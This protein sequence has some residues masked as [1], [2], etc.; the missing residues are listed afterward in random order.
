[1]KTFAGWTLLAV[2]LAAVLWSLPG[3]SVLTPPGSVPVSQS[4][5]PQA[6]AAQTAINEA[7]ILLIAASNVIA[8]NVVDG[9]STKEEGR[10]LLARVKALAADVDRAQKLLVAGEVVTAQTQAELTRKL[11]VA[12]HREVAEKARSK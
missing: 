4:L 1:M 2:V 11:L 9:V 6:Q 12:L 5:S 7:N 3:C 8:Q 10:V